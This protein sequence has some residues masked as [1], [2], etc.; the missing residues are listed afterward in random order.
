M[1]L[2]PR[3]APEAPEPSPPPDDAAARGPTARWLLVVRRH[4]RGRLPGA[5][6]RR[7][8]TS[9]TPTKRSRSGDELGDQRFRLQGTV[10][11][12]VETDRATGVTF[13]VTFNGVEVPVAHDGDPPELFE[14][15]IPVVLEG[16]LGR[17]RRRVR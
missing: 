12:D 2:T 16:Q 13:T 6:P 9:T 1:E 14:P 17:H 5:S 15:G 7:R 8:C 10:L 11:D 4:R 3:T